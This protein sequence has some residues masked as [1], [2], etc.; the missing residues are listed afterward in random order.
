MNPYPHFNPASQLP[1]VD[2]PLVLK[3]ND[4]STIRVTRPSF[5]E[6]RSDDLTFVT[7]VGS[8]ILGR[9]PWTYP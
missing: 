9:W 8:T 4:G 2:C 1:P 6:N 3:L 7:E 5:V